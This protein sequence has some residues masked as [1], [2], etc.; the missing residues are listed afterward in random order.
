MTVAF[1]NNGVAIYQH[2]SQLILHDTTT[3][4]NI[5][6]AVFDSGPGPNSVISHQGRHVSQG[7]A[8]PPS[9]PFLMSAYFAVNL[10]NG[11]GVSQC[12]KLSLEQ[13]KQLDMDQQQLA[14]LVFPLPFSFQSFVFESSE[15]DPKEP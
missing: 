10:A 15:H 13:L 12:V 11:L 9:K 1:S 4:V 7:A 8:N 6:G 3:G 2:L 5:I 14:C